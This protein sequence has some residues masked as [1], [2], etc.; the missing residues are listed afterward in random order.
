MA[1]YEFVGDGLR[2]GVGDPAVVGS[3]PE[4]GVLCD[5]GVDNSVY[6]EWA[7]EEEW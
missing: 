1:H 7:H 2:V 4:G 5:F 3:G 6:C